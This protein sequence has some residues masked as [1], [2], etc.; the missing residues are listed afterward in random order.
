MVLAPLQSKPGSVHGRPR[1][2]TGGCR[3]WA[4]GMRVLLALAVT[5]TLAGCV[6]QEKSFPMRPG[7]LVRLR[8]EPNPVPSDPS[9]VRQ[10]LRRTHQRL[11]PLLPER[12]RRVMLT[13]QFLDE[14]GQPVD[15]Y[16]YFQ[17]D[18]RTL[19]QIRQNYYGILHSAQAIGQ[20]LAID[21]PIEPWPKFQTV[22]IPVADGIEI[23]GRLGFA[24]TDDGRVRRADCI[25]I[26]PGY[27]GDNGIRR[28]RD[29]ALAIRQAGFH[30]LA[31]EL[32]GHGEAELRYPDI[33]YT[34]GALEVPDLLKV[35]E[36]LEDTYPQVSGTGLV[37]A[38]WGGNL[39]LLAAWLDGRQPDDSSIDERTAVVLGPPWPRRH[40]TAGV[41]A[42]SAVLDYEGL[43]DRLDLPQ[44][45]WA[46]PST[47]FFQNTVKERAARKGHPEVTCSL[48]RL[49]NYEFARS[50]LTR[51]W[52]V[53]DVYRFLRLIPYRGQP[54]ARKLDSA[55]MPVLVVASVNDPFLSAQDT[56]TLIDETNN[57]NV[58]ALMLRGGGHI[59]FAPY[60]RAYF[61]SLVINFFDPQVGAAASSGLRGAA[62]S[63][64]KG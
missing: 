55:R 17:K 42:L 29:L 32:R 59:G 14:Q 49:I 52:S 21:Q 26:L 54:P 40:F 64:V 22:W 30:A 2:V 51:A 50:P 12:G 24:E 18:P 16:R 13:E 58:A 8:S 48:R 39:A 11:E 35:S 34:F 3:P 33:Y 31:L 5:A 36:W 57:P 63:F 41:I 61:Y 46:N 9:T 1:R 53:I 47:H 60:N 62:A 38:C 19:N 10:W 20:R 15:V 44:D 7:D 25:V 6:F 27:L 4:P 45:T 23:S 56:A 37:G 43:M 28:T